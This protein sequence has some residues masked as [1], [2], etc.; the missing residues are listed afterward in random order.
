VIREIQDASTEL[1]FSAGWQAIRRFPESMSRLTFRN[2]ADTAFLRNGPSVR[3]LRRNLQRVKPE[4]SHRE[5]E[6]LVHSGMR[7]YLR[8]WQEAFRLPSWSRQRIRESFT[9]ENSEVLDESLR[10]GRGALMIPGHMA[11]W[12]LA[13]AWAALR[14]GSV[15]TVAERL[16]PEGVYEQ[17][18]AY[19]R[20]LGIDVIP[21]GD[22]DIVRTLTTALKA[23]KLVALLG[24]RDLGRNGVNVDLFGQ[25]A[26]IPGGPALLALL[27]G[28]PLHPVSLW[29]DGSMLRGRVLDRVE[30]PTTGERSDRIEIMTQQLADGLATGISEHPADWHM[31]QKVWV[32]D[33]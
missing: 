33:L 11:N 20:T 14:Y 15:T 32:S 12:D 1:A 19:R 2:L 29:F 8:Y 23:G 7:S 3:Q 17:F 4:L 18:L 30:V 22:A 16:K 28:A 13:G 10:G 5:L 27:S 25:T 21:H 31:M 26:R 6:D 24:D 9:L